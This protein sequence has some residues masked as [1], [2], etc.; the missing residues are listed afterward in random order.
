MFD[1]IAR[2]NACQLGTDFVEIWIKMQWFLKSAENV[3]CEKC[4]PWFQHLGIII[5]S[6]TN[7]IGDQFQ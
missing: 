2:I 4:R 3:I 7:G 5:F 6:K 1:A